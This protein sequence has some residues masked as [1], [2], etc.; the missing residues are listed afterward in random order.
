MEEGEIVPLGVARSR[1]QA[2]Q[3]VMDKPDEATGKPKV[4]SAYLQARA[5]Q[6]VE[7][8]KHMVEG[9]L[10]AVGSL[11]AELSLAMHSE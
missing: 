6:E 8:I 3:V 2:C 5:K 10:Y 7:K 1:A 11:I 4:K 9:R